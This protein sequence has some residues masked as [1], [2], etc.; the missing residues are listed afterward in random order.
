MFNG[1]IS[2]VEEHDT[3]LLPFPSPAFKVIVEPFSCCFPISILKSNQERERPGN[4]VQGLG[5]KASSAEGHGEPLE[6]LGRCSLM[7]VANAR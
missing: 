6:A 2:A 1:A 5:D 3:D 4:E 7:T